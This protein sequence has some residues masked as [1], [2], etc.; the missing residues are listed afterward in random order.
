MAAKHYFEIEQGATLQRRLRW[1]AGGK[2][3]DLSGWT[4]RCQLRPAPR[5]TALFDELSTENGRITLS[6]DGDITLLWPAD[7]SAGFEFAFAHYDLLLVAPN[8]DV[9][10]LVEGQITIIPRTTL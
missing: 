5:S 2:A 10:R 9:T 1:R 3:V 8:G 6:A 7:V 4:A